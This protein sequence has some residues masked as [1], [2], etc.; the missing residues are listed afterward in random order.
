MTD[1]LTARGSLPLIIYGAGGHGKVVIDIAR[2]V[3]LTVSLLLDDK[4]SDL[5][6]GA[7]KVTHALH[8]RWKELQEFSFLVAIGDNLSR[9]RIFT[10]MLARGGIPKSLIHPFTAV[11]VSAVICGGV[12]V[13]AGA[14]I[15]P[16]AVVE[17]D[18][19]I[20]TGASVDHDCVVGEHSHICPGVR[21]AGNVRVGPRTMIGTGASVLPG[22]HI[23]EGCRVGAGAVVNR[24]LP[25]HVIA[26]GV[27][28]RIHNKLSCDDCNR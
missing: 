22:V 17:D 23:G 7:L 25:A 21:L 10:Q 14:V 28:A 9:E 6:I 4:A 5:Q 24:D 1:A 20:N 18:C 3:G 11:S 8:A 12:S 27:P 16:E 15:N 19:I 13:C 26:F 2:Q